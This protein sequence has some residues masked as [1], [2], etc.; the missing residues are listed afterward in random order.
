L[1]SRQLASSNEDINLSDDQRAT[2]A[3]VIAVGYRL[4]V[5]HRGILV[6][7]AVA[8]REPRFLNYANDG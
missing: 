7:L 6:A 4:G 1:G 3:T 5:P 8:S 2:A